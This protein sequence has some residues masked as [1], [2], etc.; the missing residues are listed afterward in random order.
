MLRYV[1]SIWRR[2][3]GRRSRQRS[4]AERAARRAERRKARAAGTAPKKSG[5]GPK[6]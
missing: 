6:A 2:L 1:K 3:T 4:E 5:G